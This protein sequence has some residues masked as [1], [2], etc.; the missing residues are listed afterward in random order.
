MHLEDEFLVILKMELTRIIGKYLSLNEFKIFFFG[1][2][3]KGDNFSK[4]D[5]DVGIDGEKRIPA[6]IKLQIEEELE[7]IPIPYKIDLVDF[8]DVSEEFKENVLKSIE[9]VA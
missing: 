8:K 7:K 9:Y 6:G 1:S 5:I 4:A 3:V 2:R